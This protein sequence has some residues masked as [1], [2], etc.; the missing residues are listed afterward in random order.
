MMHPLS[1]ILN[2]CINASL[3]VMQLLLFR[4]E[5]YNNALLLIQST[6]SET[7]NLLVMVY[8]YPL[9]TNK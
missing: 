5:N 7:S 9:I 6:Q 3:H 4:V 8:G 1:L 2:I